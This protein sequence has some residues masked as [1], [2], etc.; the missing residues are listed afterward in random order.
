M[1]NKYHADLTGA[2]LHVPKEHDNTYHSA[3]YL[4][5]TEH[6][7]LTGTDLHIPLSHDNTYHS[8]NYISGNEN[9]VL[10]GAITGTGTTAITAVLDTDLLNGFTLKET[11]VLADS[12]AIVDSEASN[13]NK[14]ATLTSIQ[15]LIGAV[16]AGGTNPNLIKNGNF[17]GLTGT[18]PTDWDLHQLQL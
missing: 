12:V 2:D 18:T 6:A 9:I 11:P 8:T 3:T 16:G 1:A 15:T 5:S 7:T 10:S 13:V 14:K 4:S 17:A